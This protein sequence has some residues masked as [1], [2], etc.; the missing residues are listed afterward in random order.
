MSFPWNSAGSW[1]IPVEFR[2]G[3]MRVARS[4]TNNLGRRRSWETA[5]TLGHEQNRN[6]H[7]QLRCLRIIL[8]VTAD[9]SAHMCEA[10]GLRGCVWVWLNRGRAFG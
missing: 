4:K 5:D 10:V 6:D 2:W 7:P 9:V 8:V 1:W 3:F